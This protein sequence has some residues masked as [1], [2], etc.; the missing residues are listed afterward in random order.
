MKTVASSAHQSANIIKASHG[1]PSRKNAPARRP[2]ADAGQKTSWRAASKT[3]FTAK[4]T[5]ASDQPTSTL[6]TRITP[7]QYIQTARRASHHVNS[8]IE[9][10]SVRRDR[11]GNV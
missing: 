7:T 6:I 1:I 10:N 3:S 2:L 11:N 4:L 9:R 8:S 5:K